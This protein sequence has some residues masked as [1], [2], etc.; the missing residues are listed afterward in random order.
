MQSQ[1]VQDKFKATCLEKY[2]VEFPTQSDK[3]KNLRKANCIEK[4][5]VEH[6]LQIQD[7]IDRS[8]STMIEKYGFK[9]ALEIPEFKK[10]IKETCIDRYG[11][12]NPMQ[13]TSVRNK[14]KA[15][16]VEKYGF[17]NISQNPEISNKSMNAFN[18]KEYIFPCGSLVKVQGY[19]NLALDDLVS[20]G[21]TFNDIIV[22]RTKVPEIWWTD[23]NG[24][25]HRYFIDI[26]IPS[27]NKMIEVK[28]TWT[29]ESKLDDVKIKAEAC[30]NL[31][32]NFEFWI[33]D[34]K[35]VKEI[36]TVPTK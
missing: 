23:I 27:L 19:E 1:V 11:A 26:Y 35:K 20:M 15:T 4:Y 18:F 30:V 21:L 9:S 5:G 12:E 7:V 36:K 32:Y 2:G 3:V 28:S 13:N 6:S 22:C 16:C 33:Y 10:R 29:Y 8:R 14:A 17:E 24:K 34:K 25:K 31:G